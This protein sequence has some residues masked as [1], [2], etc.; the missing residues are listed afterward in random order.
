MAT[1][2]LDGQNDLYPHQLLGAVKC[3]NR[4]NV[5]MF[6]CIIVTVLVLVKS[7]STSEQ[8]FYLLKWSGLLNDIV[9]TTYDGG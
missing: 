4:S 2:M 1:S 3:L 7:R 5:L 8:G 6:T 9:V